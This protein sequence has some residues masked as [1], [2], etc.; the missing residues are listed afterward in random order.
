MA[1][2]VIPT[3]L[4]AA[5]LSLLL[6]HLSH[7]FS[8]RCTA[9]AP[10]KRAQSSALTSEVAASAGG[11]T[12][13]WEWKGHD[14]FT[15]VRKAQNSEGDRNRK[16]PSVILLH[17]FGASTTYWR[18]SI[19]VL[20]K[21]GYDVHALDLLGQGRS[22]KP[23]HSG[24]KSP[25]VSGDCDAGATSSGMAMGKISNA[26]V[27][28]SINLWASMVD[29]Y[30]RHRRLD[31][32]VLIGNSLGSLVALSAATGEF[33][34]STK[35]GGE[36][37]DAY[38]T[39]N[40]TDKQSRVKGLCLFNCAVGLNSRNLVKNQSLNPLQRAVLN[41]LFDV[42]NFLIF[43]NKILLRYALNNVV[44]KELLEDALKSLYTC[45]PDR[46]DR[47]LVDSFYYPAKMGGEGA[48]EAIRQI[49]TNN[50]GLTPMEY[51]QKYR[52]ILNSMPLHLIWGLDDS[53]T[54]IG[55]DV[56]LFYCDR[57]ANNRG[58][59]GRTTIDVVKSG[60]M[61]FDDNPSET[62]EAMLRWLEKKVL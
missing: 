19:S 48:V 4:L 5:L 31:D 32:V 39:G 8:F 57:V 27:E 38:L 46:V 41:R 24:E 36:I 56:G 29:D 47:E 14:I 43:D 23:F 33:I 61:P 42:L 40:F 9:L 50:A 21:G 10:M 34:D 22:S 53:I 26:K 54:P 11:A 35:E 18:E 58:G 37:V 55:G 2:T 15:E 3:T 17:G 45:S 44:T 59:N 16:K 51:H 52:E 30:A 28:Y 1:A 25:S 7:G 12:S 6:P 49:Y 13:F 20:Q 60:H 62:H